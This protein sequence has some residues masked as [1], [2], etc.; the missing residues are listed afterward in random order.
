MADIHHKWSYSPL[1]M[2]VTALDLDASIRDFARLCFPHV[3][4]IIQ[5]V[6]SLK[7]DSWD[8]VTASHDIEH[9]YEPLRFLDQLRRVARQSLLIYAPLEEHDRI[10]SNV[11]TI[12]HEFLKTTKPDQYWII[13]IVTWRSRGIFILMLLNS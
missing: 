10:G 12:N 3:N 13:D 8:L 2:E 11:N 5:D 7:S 6:F 1:K 4:F 9:V